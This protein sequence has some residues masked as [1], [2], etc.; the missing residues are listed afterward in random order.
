MGCKIYAEV[1]PLDVNLSTSYF[2]QDL[3]LF[4]RVHNMK[5]IKIL[6]PIYLRLPPHFL[7]K[8]TTDQVGGFMGMGK[9]P[10]S[11]NITLENKNVLI[12]QTVEMV[13]E[14]DNEQT[15]RSLLQIRIRL[16]QALKYAVPGVPK[17]FD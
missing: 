15:N 6:Q 7:N 9:K 10:S 1:T 14:V 13:F 3:K 2:R 4:A 16:I 11:V 17:Q 12:G 8:H 5:E